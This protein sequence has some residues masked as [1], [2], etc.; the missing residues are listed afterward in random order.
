MSWTFLQ[1]NENKNKNKSSFISHIYV[2]IIETKFTHIG[3]ICITLVFF[4]KIYARMDIPMAVPNYH[5][6]FVY[7]INIF[8]GRYNALNQQNPKA[9]ILSGADDDVG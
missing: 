6:G 8:I 9:K 5:I 2:Q 4:T 3:T 1:I 7:I